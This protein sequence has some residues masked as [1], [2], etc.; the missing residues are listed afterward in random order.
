M[1]IVKIFIEIL[2]NFS[3]F[4]FYSIDVINFKV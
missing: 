4:I 1:N 2:L 3:D